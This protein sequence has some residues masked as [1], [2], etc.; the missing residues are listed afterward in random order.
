MKTS[1]TIGKITEALVQVQLEVKG[2]SKDAQG[3]GYKYI[4]LDQILTLVRPVLAKHSLVLLQDAGGEVLEG[5]NVA[6][7]ETRICH[8]SG[9]W[10]CSSELKVKPVSVKAGAATTPRDLGSAI[11]YAKRYQLQALLGLNA[12]VDDDAGAVS[13]SLQNWGQKVSPASLQIMSGIMKEKNVD[14][15]KVQEIMTSTIG[16]IKASSELTQD[17][18][19][20]IIAHLQKL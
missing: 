9:E 15:T 11:T 2:I 13:E 14:K 8:V 20:K 5:Q 19:D 12:D 1:E 7:V 6:L 16:K 18:A 17:E 10:I 3:H 4:T